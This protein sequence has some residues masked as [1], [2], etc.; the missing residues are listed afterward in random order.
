MKHIYLLITAFLLVAGNVLAQ[1]DI[2][3][4]SFRKGQGFYEFQYYLN[5]FGDTIYHGSYSKIDTTYFNG[6]DYE[7]DG[8]GK[9]RYTENGTYSHGKKINEWKYTKE[10]N[11]MF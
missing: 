5:E 3:T 2:Q 6:I 4:A 9:Y 1:E 7:K 8:W 11:R 10:L